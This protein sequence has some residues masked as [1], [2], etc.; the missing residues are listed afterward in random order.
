MGNENPLF[1]II[2]PTYARP[3]MLEEA[4]ASVLGQTVEDFE[5]LIVDDGSPIPISVPDDPRIRL[6][7]Q[8]RNAGPAVSRNIGLDEAR[9][10]YIAFLDDDDLYT[11]ER[12]AIALKGLG[13]APIAICWTSFIDEPYGRGRRLEGDVSASILDGLTPSLGA[14]AL[15]RDVLCRFDERLQGTEDV[16]WWLRLAQ[17]A[18]VATE[19]EIGYLVRRHGGT[20]NRNALAIRV[21][22]NVKLF[23]LH[24]NYFRAH[25]RATAFRWKRVGLIALTLGRSR[26]ALLAFAHSLRYRPA[27]K[28]VWHLLRSLRA[29]WVQ[30]NN[31]RAQLRSSKCGRP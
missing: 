21:D 7:R 11:S 24:E 14:T 27:P 8:E 29:L 23:R 28:T 13:R 19:A 12:L 15:H 3:R 30:R 2:V 26:D 17:R 10:R 5:C 22:E 6:L 1:S 16:E 18:P 9:G 4:V 20:R 31:G 25:R